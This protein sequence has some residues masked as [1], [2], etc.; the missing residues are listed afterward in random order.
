MLQS[1]ER[2]MFAPLERDDL[3]DDRPVG[4][5][6]LRREEDAPLGAASQHGQQAK[7]GQLVPHLESGRLRG[8]R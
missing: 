4:Q 3:Q 1:R 7:A 2:S 5:L 6:G 8:P